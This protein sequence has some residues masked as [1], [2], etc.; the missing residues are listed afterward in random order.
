[1]DGHNMTFLTRGEITAY[2]RNG[3]Q[4]TYLQAIAAKLSQKL[5]ID[6]AIFRILRHT[7][8]GTAGVLGR[9]PPFRLTTRRRYKR[10]PSTDITGINAPIAVRICMVGAL[11]VRHGPVDAERQN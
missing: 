3:Q 8:T 6:T 9:T 10:G 4:T 11:P 7:P 2:G 5:S 1:M